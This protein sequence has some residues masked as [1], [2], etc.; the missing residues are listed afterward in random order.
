MSTARNLSAAITQMEARFEQMEARV[1]KNHPEYLVLAKTYNNE[2][3]QARKLIAADLFQLRDAAKILEVGAGSL[4][5]STQLASEGFQ[6]TAIEPVGDGFG[7]MA[8]FM[9]I[10]LE[11]IRNENIPMKIERMRIEDLNVINSHD[12]AFAINVME[13]VASPDAAIR[14][15]IGSL[16]QGAIFRIYCPNYDFPYEPHF[17]KILLRR[18]N[19]SFYLKSSRTIHSQAH[20]PIGLYK[21]LNWIT[22]RKIEHIAIANNLHPNFNRMAF[23]ELINRAL[24]DIY[25]ADR[26]LLLFRILKF[27][28]KMKL[29]KMAGYISYKYQPTIDVTLSK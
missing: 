18:K 13:H 26:H 5:L 16:K 6:V 2:S 8:V 19:G 9:E 17:G 24:S 28:H 20:D 14:K 7:P 22:A 4:G 29:H 27:V 1:S 21:S 10:Y 23:V 3:L 11:I 25:L 15:T 12:Y